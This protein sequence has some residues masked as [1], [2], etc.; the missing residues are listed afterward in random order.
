M[1]K[2]S[3]FIILI[4]AVGAIFYF[5]Q[6]NINTRPQNLSSSDNK[7][8]VSFQFSEQDIKQANFEFKTPVNLSTITEFISNQEAWNYQV[9]DYGDMGILI[10]QI[11]DKENGQDQKYWQY[12]VNNE[13]AQI[14]VDKYF[15]NNGENIEWKFIES[16][17]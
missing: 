10:T 4:I 17:F 6:G 13:Q 11:R 5:W 8:T 9:E 1:K 2:L 12:F 15:P 14:S 7:I 3:I 16:E